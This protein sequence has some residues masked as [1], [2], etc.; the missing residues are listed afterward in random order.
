[1]SCDAIN[2]RQVSVWNATVK[3][4]SDWQ[5]TIRFRDESGA[6]VDLTGCLF[7]WACRPSFNSSTLTA[8]MSTTDGRFTINDAVGGVVSFRLPAAITAAITAGRFVHDAEMEWPSGI[9][10]P[11]WEGSW[12][13]SREAVRGV[14]P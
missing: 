13:L 9:V 2:T 5:H 12:T 14:I 8:S 3:Q 4:G 7:R 6:P 1:M 11:L 10:E